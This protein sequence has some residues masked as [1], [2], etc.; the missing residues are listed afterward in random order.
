MQEVD[1]LAMILD[2]HKLRIAKLE[3]ERNALV[4]ENHR[5]VLAESK[6]NA[7]EP[8]KV[9]ELRRELDAAKKELVSRQDALS[10]SAA[11][12]E[13][14]RTQLRLRSENLMEITSSQRRAVEQMQKAQL[15]QTRLAEEKAEV[16]NV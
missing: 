11:E 1:K 2:E 6:R 7:E 14:L 3:A 5:L 4:S 15:M 8:V 16:A 12:C 10:A 13:G 9:M